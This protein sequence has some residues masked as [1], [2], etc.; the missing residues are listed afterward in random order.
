M[1]TLHVLGEEY[2]DEENE[3]FV[4]PESFHVELEHSLVSLSK[5]EE[6]YERPFLGTQA[7][8]DE[9]ALDYVRFMILEP[10]FPPEKFLRFT[11]DHFD[12]ID[13]YINRKMSGTTINQKKNMPRSREVISAELIYYWMNMFGIDSECK[14]WHLN[15]LFTLI[16]VHSIK[17]APPEKVDAE[18]AKAERRALNAK[19]RAE[20][21]TQG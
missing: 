20:W 17:N 2:W 14:H 5:W 9:E 16:Q 10:N 15:Q 19:R 7:K 11:Q 4:Y 18:Q 3:K 6:K 21:G 1:L 8:T 12:Q 13:A